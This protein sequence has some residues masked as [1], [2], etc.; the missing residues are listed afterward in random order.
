VTLRGFANRALARIFAPPCAAC[1]GPIPDPLDGAVC[2]ACWAS[3]VSFTPPLCLGCGDPL[4]AWRAT[5]R[6]VTRC[7]RCRRRSRPISRQASAGP[8][9]GTLRA[10]VH[11]LKYERRRSVAAPLSAL[12]RAA[13]RELL[14]EADAVVPVPLHSRRE[15]TRG[16]NQAELLATGLARPVRRLLRRVRATP[17][18]VSLPAAQRHRNVREAFALNGREAA[19][20]LPRP[21]AIGSTSPV[22]EAAVGTRALEGLIL[23][24]VDDVATTGATLEACARVLLEGGAAEVRALTAARV[25]TGPR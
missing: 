9:E 3:L 24:V 15:W 4:P 20:A 14:E 19:R 18:Q 13:G 8:Y 7:P 23:V 2:D 21:A 17:P 11:A 5:A 25:V 10:V 1:G 6:A 22:A 16:F 12:M